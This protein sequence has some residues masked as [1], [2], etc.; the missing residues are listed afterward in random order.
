MGRLSGWEGCE[1]GMWLQKVGA[2]DGSSGASQ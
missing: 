1:G 2:W